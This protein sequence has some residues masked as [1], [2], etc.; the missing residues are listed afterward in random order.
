MKNN[1]MNTNDNYFSWSNISE[2]ADIDSHIKYASNLLN[3]YE[4]DERT[5]NNLIK[6]L[7]IISNKQND[8]LLN[9]SV[10]GE[11][12]TGKSSFINALVGYELLAINVLQGTTV[13]IT[14]IEYGEEFSITLYD[15]IGSASTQIYPSIQALKEKLFTYTTDPAYAKKI[16]NVKI[17]IPSDILKNGFRIIDTPGTNSLELWHEDITRR[18]INEMSDLSI[19]LM[20][21]QQP[22]PETLL[23]F[24]EETLNYTIKDCA[25]I[26]NKIDLIKKNERDGIIKFIE[27]KAK[28]T[29][30]I[31]NPIVLPFAS[32]AL[33]N[34]FTDEK[35]E[36]DNNSFMLTTN[37]LQLLLSHTAKRKVQAQARKVLHLIDEMYSTLTYDI[38]NIAEDCN[39]QLQL[40][41]RSKQTDLRPFV[42]QQIVTRQRS[43]NSNIIGIRSQV[44]GMSEVSVNKAIHRINAKIQELP[45]LDSLS[46]YIKDTLSQDIVHEGESI[47]N[48]LESKFIEVKKF[49]NSEIKEFQKIF[50]KEFEKL[51]IL[52]TKFNVNPKNLVRRKTAITANI[53]PVTN[54]ITE[55]LSNE[56]RAFGGGAA[57]G[58]TIGTIIFPGLGTAIGAFI[59]FIAGSAAAP[60]TN[61]VKDKIKNKLSIPLKSYLNSVASDCISNFDSYVSDASYNLDKEINR[62]LLTYN[63]TIQCEIKQWETKQQSLNNK[64]KNIQIEID[65]IITRQHSIR[66][67]VS[68]I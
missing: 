33:T 5:K 40:L 67:I 18:A 26:A 28:N 46:I 13:A 20:N 4:W 49:F 31:E 10:I 22:M 37:S 34:F 30:D 39:Q 27:N 36:V 44:L 64:I 29:F 6:Q 23:L 57:A 21:A 68:T 45:N 53:T 61:E 62:Y 50:E 58:A 55:E 41:E 1:K 11:F 48:D 66:N 52:P 38:N 25:F 14:V 42:Q 51:K 17:T 32:A 54:L 63:D 2:M 19:V 15:S 47:T 56:N 12:S 65:S 35:I 7:N 60:N 9:I 16:N 59:G 24:I 43:F 8:K 3:K